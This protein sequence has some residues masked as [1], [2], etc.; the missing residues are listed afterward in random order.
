MQ[1]SN[2]SRSRHQK[3]HARRKEMCRK[4]FANGSIPSGS[5]PLNPNNR[6]WIS[7]ARCWRHGHRAR[8]AASV[9]WFRR[10]FASAR[11]CACSRAHGTGFPTMPAASR[12][13]W[14]GPALR[15]P[16]F[17]NAR[18]RRPATV[19]QA[20]LWKGRAATWSHLPRQIF[21]QRAHW[22][23]FSSIRHN[24]ASGA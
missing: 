15:P 1:P 13:F 4:T 3:S 5:R 12:N 8:R 2:S 7:N 14:R 21:R 11:H 16:C 23:A 19:P 18:L 10:D 6:V 22:F 24:S 9:V 17:D 20:A